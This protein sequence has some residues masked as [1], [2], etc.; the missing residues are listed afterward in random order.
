M[1]MFC[2]QGQFCG[3]VIHEEKHVINYALSINEKTI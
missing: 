1:L 2:G 3:L